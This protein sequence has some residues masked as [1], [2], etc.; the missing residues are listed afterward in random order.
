[1]VMHCRRVLVAG[2]SNGALTLNGGWFVR[3]HAERQLQRPGQF[4]YLANDGTTDSNV[5]TVSITVNAVNDAPVA[6]A[7]GPYS[8]VVD[9]LVLFDGS[10]SFDLDGT[11]V[12]YSWDF[13]DGGTATGVAPTHTYGASGPFTATLTVTD[14]GGLTDVATADVT[15]TDAPNNVP[16][17]A[18]DAYSTDED[19]VLN[20]AAPGVLGNDTDADGDALSAVL[21]A[22]PANGALTLNGDGSFDYTPNAD[23]NGSDSFTYVAND[24]VDDSNIATVTI[25]IAPVND[26]P[27]A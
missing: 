15:I 23:F 18:D 20:V 17:A 21:A 26:A 12:S 14:D 24:G 8:G 22:G 16:V 7:N 6:D 9:V 27:V 4:T 19:V 2:S 3:L 5:A 1:M 10:G 25:T 13:G 11:I